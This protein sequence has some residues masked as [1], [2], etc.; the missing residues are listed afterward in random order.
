MYE[1]VNFRT[2]HFLIYL[3]Q[4]LHKYHLIFTLNYILYIYTNFVNKIN[5]QTLSPKSQQC[6]AS[7]KKGGS[8]IFSGPCSNVLLYALGSPIPKFNRNKFTLR[9]SICRSVRFS[10][11]NHK[12]G[13]NPSPNLRKQDT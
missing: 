1:V 13:Y 6:H 9:P 4:K 7:K 3:I 10:S 12:T 8:N 2:W 5:N 11:L